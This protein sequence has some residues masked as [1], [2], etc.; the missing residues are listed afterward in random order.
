MK[1]AESKPDFKNQ[2]LAPSQTSPRAVSQS[3]ETTSE[4]DINKLINDLKNTYKNIDFDF[5]SVSSGQIKNYATSQS[6]INNVAIAPGLLEKMLSDDS[7]RA[8]VEQVL[9][10]L[11]SYQFSSQV[12]ALLVNKKLT[13]M[14]LILDENGEV[15][16]WTAMKEQKTQN[17][18]PE[19][20]HQAGTQDFSWS[21]TKEAKNP[22]SKPYKY[23]QSFNMMRLAGAK[24]VASVRG[25]I[26][27]N[28]SEIA[29]VKLEVTDAAEA[30]VI[31]RRIKNVI[32]KGDIKI[33]RLHREEQLHRRQKAAKKRL[34]LKLEKQLAEELRRKR[35]ARK[36][37]EHCQTACMEDVFIKP[38]TAD[39]R[40]KQ[41]ADQYTNTMSGFVPSAPVISVS[42]PAQA[43][44]VRASPVSVATVDCSA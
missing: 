19:N 26:A 30:A 39:Y 31:I 7:V 32:H 34:K 36:A 12:E 38:S 24:N 27:A 15:T 3:P 2:V 6:G 33:A 40:F 25:V 44:E 20:K 10:S 21:K 42:S 28:R 9:N 37:Q 41:I 5:I 23:S 11:N 43:V 29:K 22:Y 18:F 1:V 8:K 14:G 35:T 4:T 13:G 16:K 17:F